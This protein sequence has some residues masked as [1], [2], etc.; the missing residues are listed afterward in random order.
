MLSLLHSQFRKVATEEE[1]CTPHR[2]QELG[3]FCVLLVN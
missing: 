1:N 2:A 3:T